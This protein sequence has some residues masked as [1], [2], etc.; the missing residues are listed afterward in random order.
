MS[1][2]ISR[3]W[4]GGCLNKLIFIGLILLLAG[5]SIIWIGQGFSASEVART[6]NKV[7]PGDSLY[8]DS[9]AT[10]NDT[11]S[12]NCRRLIRPINISDIKRMNIKDWQKQKL[13]NTIDT[14]NHKTGLIFS[15]Y[16]TSS[17][18]MYQ[19]GTSFIGTY[20][21][22]DSTYQPF[23]DKVKVKND[24][25]WYV[26]KPNMK[27]FMDVNAVDMPKGYTYADSNYYVGVDRTSLEEAPAFN[28]R[29]K[30]SKKP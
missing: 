9:F 13:A 20:V 24:Y 6:W 14:L 12:V 23:T 30:S 25:H 26:I 3:W 29:Y 27:I 28:K 19:Q 10:V 22:R 7:K 5:M 21:S 8:T 2:F 15:A 11:F 17:D 1:N 16:G 18:K 4:N